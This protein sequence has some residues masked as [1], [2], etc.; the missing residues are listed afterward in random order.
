MEAFL[1]QLGQEALNLAQQ[2]Q[3]GWLSP[4]FALA[5][6]LLNT[7]NPCTISVLPLWGLYLFG[8]E[9]FQQNGAGPRKK[10]L[11]HLRITLMF[12][13]GMVLTLTLLGILALE[14][15]LVV[16]GAWNVSWV[17][18]LL[19]LITFF[20]GVSIL[21]NWRGFDRLQGKTQGLFRLSQHPTLNALKPLLMGAA[22]ALIL[23]PC[24]TPFLLA[25]TLLLV[26]SPHPLVSVLNILFYSLGQGLLF[27]MLP[28]IMPH[29][30][31]LLSD[32]WRRAL[33]IFSGLLLIL[34][35]V[36]MLLYPLGG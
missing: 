20:L 32:R 8:K 26:Q 31:R 7:L 19:G 6:G 34:I 24:S 21:I 1:S 17:W 29:L 3:F 23:S 4:L 2:G 25:L 28:F 22:F 12:T 10:S 5:L 33:R 14:L 30:Q 11:R 18:I 15:R 27:L 9:A 35:A 13:L 16:F 36:W